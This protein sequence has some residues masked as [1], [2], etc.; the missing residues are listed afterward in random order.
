MIYRRAHCLTFLK[1]SSAT[2][3]THLAVC[4]PTAWPVGSVTL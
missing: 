3:A 1:N 2:G 4:V